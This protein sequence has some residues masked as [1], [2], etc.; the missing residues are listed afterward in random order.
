MNEYPT[1]SHPLIPLP[2]FQGKRRSGDSAT[3]QPCRPYRAPCC[4][5]GWGGEETADSKDR[6]QQRTGGDRICPHPLSL[7]LSHWNGEDRCPIEM[8]EM[9]FHRGIANVRQEFFRGGM[10]LRTTDTCDIFQ[11]VI[12]FI[13]KIGPIHT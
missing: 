13:R 9:R 10:K 12:G 8:L 2:L 5:L 6:R 11:D 7:S 3:Q 1:R 4:A